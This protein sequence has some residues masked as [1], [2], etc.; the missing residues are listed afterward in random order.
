MKKTYIIPAVKSI[1]LC[2]E[3]NVLQATSSFSLYSDEEVDEAKSN[4]R[5]VTEEIWG[6]EK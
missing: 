2:T 1:N 6:F 3:E 5:S 4:H